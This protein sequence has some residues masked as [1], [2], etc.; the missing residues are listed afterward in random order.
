MTGSVQEGTLWDSGRPGFESEF[1]GPFAVYAV[2]TV[3]L[4]SLHLSSVSYVS[5]SEVMLQDGCGV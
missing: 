3:L 1:V 4:I 5:T 2:L